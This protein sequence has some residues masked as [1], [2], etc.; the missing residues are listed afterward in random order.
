MEY[1]MSNRKKIQ[2]Q[3]LQGISLML[4]LILPAMAAESSV[5]E[6][7]AVTPPFSLDDPQRI[8]AGLKRFGANCSAY[9][10]GFEG[11]GGKTPAFRGRQ[12]LNAEEVF[13]TI[14]RGRI[15]SDVMPSF[16][17]SFTD[18]KRWELVAYIMYLTKQ[19]PK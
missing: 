1:A 9:C 4:C 5:N 11:S 3:L 13:L 19:P 8:E 16:A 7:N 12:D 15:G 17:N 14:T 6:K 10:H 18:E 2:Y